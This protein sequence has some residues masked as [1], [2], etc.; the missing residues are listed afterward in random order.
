MDFSRLNPRRVVAGGICSALLVLSLLFMPWYSLSHGIPRNSP[1]NPNYASSWVCG[2]GDFKCTGFET[3]PIARWLLILAAV[4]PV[5]L[6]YILIRG[7]R[8]SYPTGEMTMV[9]GFA[10][11][12]LILYNGVID[13]PGS[14]AAEI[15]VSLDYG[16]FVA[17]LA[18]LGIGITGLS[19]SQ[20]GQRRVR[21]APGTV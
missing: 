12:V 16:Y 13:K 14:G 2:T 15:G 6:A 5:I 19:R 4:A 3:F 18:S 20:E 11:F 1:A 7:H 21:K 9:A 17:L 8:T 10:A